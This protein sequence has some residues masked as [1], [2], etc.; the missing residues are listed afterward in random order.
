MPQ[1]GK[2]KSIFVGK[3]R[4]R[5]S[6]WY[7]LFNVHFIKYSCAVCKTL[8][9][10]NVNTNYVLHYR[11]IV[12]FTLYENLAE[13]YPVPS[14]YNF[15]CR[16]LLSPMNLTTS[17]HYNQLL[18]SKFFTVLLFSIDFRC[19]N[20]SIT[21]IHRLTIRLFLKVHF[22]CIFFYFLLHLEIFI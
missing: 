18:L 16:F 1:F 12:I 8:S 10:R 13:L 22:V 7:G 21:I 17:S 15:K 11:T 19:I 6:C 14:F 20:Q 9:L 5:S 2:Y 4:S 3:K